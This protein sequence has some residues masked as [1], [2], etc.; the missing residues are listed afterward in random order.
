MH[1]PESSQEGLYFQIHMKKPRVIKVKV[2]AQNHTTRGG[3]DGVA[4]RQAPGS[5]QRLSFA[6]P[7]YADLH[8]YF[9][10]FLLFSNS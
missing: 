5:P 2:C 7:P 10:I 9:S 6:D 4:P 8:L 1:F 3:T